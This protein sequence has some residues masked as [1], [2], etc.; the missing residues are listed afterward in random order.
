MMNFNF[1]SFSLILC[2]CVILGISLG[3]V[4]GVFLE[5]NELDF[6]I[7]SSAFLASIGSGLII[8][9]AFSKNDWKKVSWR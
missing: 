8:M 4:L 2:G 9:G 1:K 5:K 6:F 3:V 7:Y